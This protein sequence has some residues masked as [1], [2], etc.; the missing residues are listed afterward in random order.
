MILLT[1]RDVLQSDKKRHFW[2]YFT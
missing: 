1:K 2:K